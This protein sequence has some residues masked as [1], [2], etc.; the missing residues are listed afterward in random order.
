M[1][2]VNWKRFRIDVIFSTIERGKVHSQYSLPDG[3]GLF[4]VGAKKGGCGVMKYCG[5]DEELISKGNC[6]VFI[7]NGEGSVGYCNYIDRDFMASGD[8]MLAYG[9]FLNP[10][11][12]LFIITLLDKDQNT[13]LVENMGNM[14]K[15]RPSHY[16]H[17][18]MKKHQI[19]IGLKIIPKHILFPH[20]QS[21]QN[22]F[23]I[24]NTIE[25]L[26]CKNQLS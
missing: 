8:L 6:V 15:K 5:Y 16:Q 1:D 23:G 4:Y 22:R 12:A 2:I 18:T 26:F 9:D 25:N 14:L 20:Y 17:Q 19:G 21:A 13:H 10:Y 11:T 24:I 7:C 3:N